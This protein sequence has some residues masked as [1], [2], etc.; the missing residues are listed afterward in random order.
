MSLGLCP[1]DIPR[2]WLS[3]L[4]FPYKII[5]FLTHSWVTKKRIC[6]K[7]LTTYWNKMGN[8]RK[9]AFPTF[10][11]EPPKRNKRDCWESNICTE[12]SLQRL[13]WKIHCL[14][15]SDGD[16]GAVRKVNNKELK[17]CKGVQNYLSYL[18]TH[19]LKSV[20][21]NHDYLRCY[22]KPIPHPILNRV[23]ILLLY[24]MLNNKYT[25]MF[26]SFYLCLVRPQQ[27]LILIL[28]M[29]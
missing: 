15:E 19:N 23:V 24:F 12:R 29:W 11:W 1:Q 18:V 2:N 26:I 27:V 21:T 10:I 4:C 5:I 14:F 13:W 6:W 16:L 20:N 7:W 25:L 28:L 3:F 8:I 22:E 17:S 9:L